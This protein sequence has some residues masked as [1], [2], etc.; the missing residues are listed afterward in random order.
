MLTYEQTS[1]CERF[2]MPG[3]KTWENPLDEAQ[4][5]QVGEK[6]RRLR[7][8]FGWSQEELAVQAGISRVIVSR[9]EGARANQKLADIHKIFGVFGESLGSLD[10]IFYGKEPTKKVETGDLTLETAFREVEGAK[11]RLERATKILNRLILAQ[12]QRPNA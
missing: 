4:A 7:M 1:E 3:E 8:L 11:K 5:L 9:Y 12:Q 10:A 2:D 6:I